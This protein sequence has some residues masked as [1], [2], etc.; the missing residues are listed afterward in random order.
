[1]VVAYRM[2]TGKP[3]IVAAR[4]TSGSPM[5]MKIQPRGILQMPE[6]ENREKLVSPILR[7]SATVGPRES[8]LLLG[9]VALLRISR[10]RNY[11]I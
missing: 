9:R 2:C 1:M 7:Y 10:K 6:S 3:A 4:L 8:L 5:G 11:Y